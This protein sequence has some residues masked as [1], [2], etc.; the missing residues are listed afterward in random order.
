MLN[1]NPLI[2]F[3]FRPILASDFLVVQ[4]IEDLQSLSR[5]FEGPEF[6]EDELDDDYLPKIGQSIPVQLIAM[7]DSDINHIY[8]P[9]E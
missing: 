5:A 8:H 6:H 9:Q 4:S 3:E 7:L 1:I 2:F